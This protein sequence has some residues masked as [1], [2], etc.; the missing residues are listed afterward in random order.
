MKNPFGSRSKIVALSLLILAMIIIMYNAPSDIKY[1]IASSI[2][3]VSLVLINYEY[4]IL[5]N[6]TKNK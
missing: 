6:K 4:F 5:Y 3:F 2:T 1:W